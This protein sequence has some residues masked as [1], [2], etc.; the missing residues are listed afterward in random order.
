MQTVLGRGLRPRVPQGHVSVCIVQQQTGVFSTC[1]HSAAHRYRRGTSSPCH[2]T[3]AASLQHHAWPSPSQPRK[4]PCSSQTPASS[5][6]VTT[7]RALPLGNISTFGN[8]NWDLICAVSAAVAAYTWVKVFD[9]LAT[10]GIIDQASL[11]LVGSLAH[12]VCS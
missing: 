1:K 7:C 9:K 11:L 8:L 10:S 5:R 4:Q 2:V 6:S 3:P 12:H